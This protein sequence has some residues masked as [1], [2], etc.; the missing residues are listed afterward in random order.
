VTDIYGSCDPVTSGPVM[1]PAMESTTM[2]R[3]T[4][5]WP[6]PRLAATV[7]TP[8]EG[9]AAGLER[10][11]RTEPVTLLLLERPREVNIAPRGSVSAIFRLPSQVGGER[12]AIRRL[13]EI[14]E[15]VEVEQARLDNLSTAVREA[16]M[17]AME[18]AHSYDPSL[19][20][21]VEVVVAL[22]RISVA[23]TDLGGGDSILDRADEP[24]LEAK[25]RG[26][27]SPRGWGLFLMRSL[28]DRVRE[29]GDDERHTLTLELRFGGGA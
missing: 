6:R 22:D 5:P 17:N 7:P 2:P 29:T 18:H 3:P 27:Q 13:Q 25:L 9:L 14:L 12:E 24:D 8:D 10:R 26:E 21:E 15:G 28:V 1:A 16:V 19:E 4:P 23:V 11:S 20:V